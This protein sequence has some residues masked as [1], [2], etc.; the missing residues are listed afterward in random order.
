MYCPARLT[1]EATE[2]KSPIGFE[3]TISSGRSTE[4]YSSSIRSGRSDVKESLDESTWMKE[5]ILEGL[6]MKN[7]SSVLLPG[8][9][10]HRIFLP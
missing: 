6:T 2:L 4:I 8:Y 7:P 5:T 10:S 1:V 3:D 9:I